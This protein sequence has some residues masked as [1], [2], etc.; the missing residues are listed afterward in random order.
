MSETISSNNIAAS[1]INNHETGSTVSE[2]HNV[3]GSSSQDSMITRGKAGIRK[4]NPKY[5][6]LTHR[7]TSPTPTTLAKALKDSRWSGAMGEEIE[8]CAITNTWS[9]VPR[10][11]DMHVLGNKWIH[12]VKLNADGTAKGYRSRLVAQGNNQE[13]GV[14]YLETYSPVV[15][16]ATV[17]IVLHL[18]T[19]MQ[20]DV[21]QIDVK[22]AFLHG[23]LT[24]TV[25]MKQ[26]L[27]FVDKTKPD[28]VCLLHKSLY[29]LKQSPRAW[30]NKF[31]DFLIEFGFVCSVKDP[32]CSSTLK[33]AISS[34]YCCML[35]TWP[36]RKTT[37]SH[38]KDCLMS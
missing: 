23:D 10:T 15:R 26:P 34:C 4:P 6:L 5:A 30:F 3:P 17:R 13:E 33:K 12:K 7:T 38:L 24:E 35:T 25:Y 9:F 31:S 28:H 2:V 19:I 8:N 20:W 36:S 11:K 22:N 16:T 18:A 1:S 27:G 21:K 14:D 37:Q 29:G 32:L